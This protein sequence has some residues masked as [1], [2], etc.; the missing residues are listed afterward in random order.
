MV[1]KSTL[2]IHPVIFRVEGNVAEVSVGA[3]L[4]LFVVSATVSG[5]LVFGKPVLL[6]LDGKKQD[7]VKLFLTTLGWMVV[8]LILIFV[9]LAVR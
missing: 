2:S 5:A 9:I 3:V 4:M 7:A 8:I 6:Y 1:R